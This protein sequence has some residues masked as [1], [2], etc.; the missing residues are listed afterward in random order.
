MSILTIAYSS[1]VQSDGNITLRNSQGDSITSKN[2]KEL[3]DFL[4]KNY[5]DSIN[6]KMTWAMDAFIAP[7]LRLL[8]DDIC[9]QLVIEPDCECLWGF[10]DDGIKLH[11]V[12]EKVKSAKWEEDKGL[13]SLY[14][15][16]QTSFGLQVYG[17]YKSYF[18]N[19]SQFFEDDSEITDLNVILAKADELVSAFFAMGLNP[20]KMSSP[21][22]VYQSNVLEHISFP[23]VSDVPETLSEAECD[24]LVDWA[25]QILHREWTT[26]LAVGRW[27]EGESFD[28]DLAGAYNFLFSELY[29]YKYATFWKSTTPMKEADYGLLKGKITINPD[30]KCSPICF[31]KENGQTINPVGSS[32]EDII[33]LPEV[34]WI[35]RHKIGTFEMDYGY[36]WKQNAP[37]QPFKV[38]MS[39][40]FNQR[41]QG[42]LVK[43]LAKRIGA[44]AWSKCIQRATSEG[45][46]KFYSPLLA[47]QVKTNCRL[48]VADFIWQHSLQDDILYIAT[49]GVRTTTPVSL[50][51]KEGMGEWVFKGSDACIILSPS[52][53]YTPTHKPG[54]LYFDDIVNMIEQKPK[55]TY[56]SATKIR[57]LTL[58]EALET[59]DLQGVGE[60]REFKTSID[61]VPARIAQDLEFSD[62]PTCGKDLIEGKYYGRPVTL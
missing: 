15:H 55:E 60:L 25:E 53:I 1:E 6:R 28:Y 10:T 57:P 9:R 24:E 33:T 42:G 26:N 21:I 22:S 30:V 49:D 31:K 54:G 16:R 38:P 34:R 48:M 46:N 56:Y 5:T 50:P 23:T 61:L 43:I 41:Q 62:F 37:V 35:Y 36:F 52:F 51:E 59:E 47:L 3:L 8:G 19:L 17:K 39:K 45:V 20:M 13:Y 14:Y 11:D 7:I 4:S 12:E 2:P 27:Q 32:W 18:Y 29:D 58:G 40:I 44:S